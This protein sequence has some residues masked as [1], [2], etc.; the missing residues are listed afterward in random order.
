MNRT[1]PPA[2]LSLDLDNL[3]A[4]LRVRG[5]SAW[6]SFPSY[7]DRA[8]P[9]ILSFLRARRL[10]ITFFVVGQDAA[11]DESVE[12]IASVAAAG[13]EIANHSF[14]HLPWMHMNS[15]QEI[16]EELSRSEEA[17][18][19]VTGR[20]TTGFRGP[21]FS[22]SLPMLEALKR[23]GYL[24]DASTFPTFIGPLARAYY[25]ARAKFGAAQA[26]HLRGLYGNLRDGLRPLRPYRWELGEGGLLEIPVTTFPG[27]RLPVHLSY[28]LFLAQRSP[29]A[30]RSYFRAALRACRITRT[31]M[32]LLLHP[33]DF[34]GREDVPQMSFFPGMTMPAEAKLEL[35]SDV[36]A[37][38]CKEFSVLPMGQFA[39]QLL[40]SKTLP[41]ATPDFAVTGRPAC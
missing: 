37:A 31:P 34:L 36:L 3:W 15:G 30:A 20:H 27:V 24:Y 8:V 40:D 41:A 23:R 5:D 1:R 32:S 25:F 2:T 18:E 16:E 26:R 21:G 22:L 6:E 19:R 39:R 33:T 13:H 28:L 29:A 35:L 11:R 38:L 17:I 4:Y 7:F 10:E 14:H 9:R 12:A